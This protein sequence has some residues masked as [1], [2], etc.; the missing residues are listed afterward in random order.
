M[1][2]K[3]FIL[4]SKLISNLKSNKFILIL[5]LTLLLTLLIIIFFY[6]YN[7]LFKIIEGNEPCKF[8]DKEKLKKDVESKANKYKRDKPNLSNTQAILGRVDNIEVDI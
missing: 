1:S 4:N 3:N 6:N 7:S 2:N 8:T 5:L